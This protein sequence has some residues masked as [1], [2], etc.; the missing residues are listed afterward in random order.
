MI[1]G[2]SLAA[3]A[4]LA[5]EFPRGIA[6]PFALFATWVAIAL[7]YRGLVLYRRSTRQG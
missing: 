3:L 2:L 6:Y 5:F 1:A 7:L 4:A